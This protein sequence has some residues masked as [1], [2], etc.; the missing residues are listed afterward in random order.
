MNHDSLTPI[1][2]DETQAFV[3]QLNAFNLIGSAVAFLDSSRNTVFENPAFSKLNREL[4]DSPD[5]M[6]S[7]DSLLS[8]PALQAMFDEL[9]AND[10]VHVFS[11]R[12]YY[13][14]NIYVELSLVFTPVIAGADNDFRG[15]LCT[16]GEES[17]DFGGRGLAKTQNKL[18]EM[19]NRIKVLDENVNNNNQLIRF[20]FK[21]APIAIVMF[22]H[23]RQI[24]NINTQAEK[25]FRLTHNEGIGE[26]CSNVLNCYNS[27][28]CCPV[29]E[30]EYNRIDVDRV[31]TVTDST[32]SVP[33]LRSAVLFDN[34][35]EEVIIEAF[36]NMQEIEQAKLES[37]AKSTFLSN[38]S[39]E[40]RTPLTAILGYAEALL[41]NKQ[42]MSERI[43]SINTIIRS[44]EH[45]RQLLDNILDISK[46]EAGSMSVEKIEIGIFEVVDEI[47]EIVTQQA[48]LKGLDFN[49]K[50]DFPLPEKIISDPVRVKQ[51]LINLCSNAIK[52]TGQGSVEVHISYLD[53]LHK[54]LF[55]VIDT[56]I[57]ISQQNI[58]TVFGQYEQAEMYTTRLYGGSG[59]GLHIS[60]QLAL[61]LGGDIR[62]ESQLG[63][64]SSFIFDID[65]GDCSNTMVDAVMPRIAQNAESEANRNR[66]DQLAGKILLV[67]DNLDNQDL[68][69]LLIR[70]YGGDVTVAS[71][72]KEG[73]ELASNNEF[74]LVL[75][76][77]QMP[78]MNGM[79][80][81]VCLRKMGYDRPVV[82]LTANVAKDDVI[83]YSQHGCNGYLSKPINQDEFYRV[84]RAH[85]RLASNPGEKLEPL[86]STLLHDEIDLSHLVEKYV[87]NF[88]ELLSQLK[89]AFDDKDWGSLEK[90]VHDLKSTSGNLGFMEVMT[91]AIRM[92]Y[93]IEQRN[94]RG[95]SILLDQL[96]VLHQRMLL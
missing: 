53:D 81:I 29:L 57:G 50:Y 34:C 9:S 89:R 61:L 95:L 87:G 23:N 55:K 38:M 85:L 6:D 4:R 13:S 28:G 42:S 71:N 14:R 39:H 12:F 32:Q 63:K 86:R 43:N 41:D 72:G 65:A 70:K 66:R 30:A 27:C 11:R 47:V 96:D 59:I 46:I 77:M 94:H 62:V 7:C 64:G 25:L 58:Q 1:V 93:D 10:S 82:A 84:L 83:K 44:G 8:C 91:I 31:E 69:T 22:N 68:I 60:K 36:M 33:L 54:L 17:I 51:V 49:V 45:L 24:V 90:Q 35:T 75:M 74:D 80:A 26:S 73:V 19:K 2:I 67:E 18:S 88:H 40:I 78:V 16:I 52:F 56:G 21:D 3:N 92:K 20:L 15:T 48:T 76:D 37:K 79:E 5:H